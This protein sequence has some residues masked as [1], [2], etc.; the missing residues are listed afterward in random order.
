MEGGWGAEIVGGGPQWGTLKRDNLSISLEG[1][2]YIN[3]YNH[4]SQCQL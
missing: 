4:N 3:L 2:Q 1:F